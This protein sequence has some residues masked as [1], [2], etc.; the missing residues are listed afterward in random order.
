M[1]KNITVSDELY[2][3]LKEQAAQQGEA[4][5]TYLSRGILTATFVVVMGVRISARHTTP[6]PPRPIWLMRM[7]GPI[8][9][10]ARNMPTSLRLRN[11]F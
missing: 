10:P 8:L 4:I 2:F 5:E 7:Y 9:S 6:R 3:R 11:D 1:S